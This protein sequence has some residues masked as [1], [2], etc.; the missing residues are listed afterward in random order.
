MTYVLYTSLVAGINNNKSGWPCKETCLHSW[1]SS[2][3]AV[4]QSATSE[5][6]HRL[7]RVTPQIFLKNLKITPLKL[8]FCLTVKF[9]SKSNSRPCSLCHHTVDVVGFFWRL[10]VSLCQNYC[11]ELEFKN[12]VHRLLMPP[13]M[14]FGCFGYFVWKK[15]L[16]LSTE[17]PVR[18]SLA[19]AFLCQ[20]KDFSHSLGFLR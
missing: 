4:F 13:P 7:L 8:S 15:R 17:L 12:V 1:E 2:L 14:S 6:I 9:N 3:A 11:L 18:S 10:R 19:I 16:Q 5:I 20:S